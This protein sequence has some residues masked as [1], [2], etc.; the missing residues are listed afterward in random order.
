MISYFI[1]QINH[2][3]DKEVEAKQ[4]Q[5]ENDKIELIDLKQRLKYEKEAF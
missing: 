1:K 2:K 5:L 3:K 4:K